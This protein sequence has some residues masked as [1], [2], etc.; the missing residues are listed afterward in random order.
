MPPCTPLPPATPRP[1][2]NAGRR[3]F[4]V[5]GD[6]GH[7]TP[8]SNYVS[9]PSTGAP[10]QQRLRHRVF[11][12]M[13]G[14]QQMTIVTAQALVLH[15]QE[16]TMAVWGLNS[17]PIV[18][19]GS[20]VCKVDRTD[21]PDAVAKGAARR[22]GALSPARAATVLV[23]NA[24]VLSPDLRTLCRTKDKIQDKRGVMFPEDSHWRRALRAKQG[25]QRA[26]C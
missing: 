18:C 13:Q 4:T 3:R 8:D 20:A 15:A 23:V 5:G 14:N 17:S 6:L 2:A 22:G 26:T 1:A 9:A 16:T 24:L 25:A 19:K 7:I 12:G 10:A 21:L 11:W